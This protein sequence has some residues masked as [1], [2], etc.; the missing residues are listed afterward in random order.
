MNLTIYQSYYEKEQ[1]SVIDNLFT[2]YDNTSNAIPH[3]REYL[4]WKHL[5]GRHENDDLTWGLLSWR[6]YEKTKISPKEL[7]D[8]INQNPDYDVYHVDPFLDVSISYSNLWIHGE[9][10][11]PGMLKFCEILFP[12]IG[13]NVSPEKLI[14]KPEHFATCNFFIGNNLFWKDWMNFIDSILHICFEHD[15]LY[16]YLYK[17][18]VI[19]NGKRITNFSFVIERLFSTF[20]F[21]QN[22]LKVKK[23]PVTHLSY[24]ERFGSNHSRMV[25]IYQERSN[26]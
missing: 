13:I 19:Y 11:H 2:P 25:D 20:L 21:L 10:W 16:D 1:L 26:D 4:L 7:H 3:L 6:W 15:I 17:N 9:R 22:K 14:F 8:W 18:T 24:R 12:K 5:Y 23:F